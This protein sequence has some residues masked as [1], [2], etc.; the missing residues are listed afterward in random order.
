MSDEINVLS[1]TQVIVIDSTSDSVAVFNAGPAGP[2]GPAGDPGGPPGPEGPQGEIGPMGPQG[3]PGPTGADGAAGTQGPAGATGPAGPPGPTG[4]DSTVPGPQG[5]QGTTGPQG[6][7]GPKGDTG[8]TGPQGP[9]GSG[10]GL[11]DGVY[12]DVTVSGTGTN[13]QINP[14]AVGTAELANQAV[15][16]AKLRNVSQENRI[17]GRVTAGAGNVEEIVCTPQ[18]MTLLDDISSTEMRSTLGLGSLATK[19]SILGSDIQSNQV[20]NTDLVDMPA[21]TIK[22]NNT[23]VTADPK[24]LTVAEVQALLSILSQAAA[25]LRY[26]Q[27]TGGTL[28]GNL[29]G[30][31]VIISTLA[32]KM[33]AALF[34]QAQGSGYIQVPSGITFTSRVTVQTAPTAADDAANKQYVDTAPAVINNQTGTTYQFVLADQGKLITLNNA[35]AITVTVPKNTGVAFP[36]GTRID[37]LQLGA[38]KVTVAPASFVNLY[39]TPSLGFRAQYSS[40]TLI[41]IAIDT[42]VL[43]GDLA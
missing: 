19:S 35:G 17:L 24:D 14:L 28:T 16:Y 11:T 4:A 38:G 36:V 27:L 18:A 34:I 23:A 21:N 3:P 33:D 22:G 6:P 32:G 5:P 43:V 1:R 2:P 42:W 13:I 41:Q 37:L 31:N 25:D 12:G 29:T 9:A 39:G 30:T 15:T 20:D 8:A 26:L 10:G 40:A 7:Q